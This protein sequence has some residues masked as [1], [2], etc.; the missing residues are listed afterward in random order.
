MNREV[1]FH[2]GALADS[3]EEQANA[4]GFTLGD[5]AE[6]WQN[7]NHA[8]IMVWIHGIA[9]DSEKDKM[10]ARFQKKMI[11]DLKPFEVNEV[12]VSEE[13]L[14]CIYYNPTNKSCIVKNN[15]D[16][17]GNCIDF[18]NHAYEE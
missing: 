17:N 6:K 7:I 4:Q 3:L 1:T 12:L 11:K 10:M 16:H 2:Y 13:C 18:D 9:T 14:D 5:K 15:T 8:M